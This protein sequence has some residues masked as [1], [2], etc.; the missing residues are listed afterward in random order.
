L[1]KE[2]KKEVGK[3]VEFVE[4]RHKAMQLSRDFNI[5]EKGRNINKENHYHLLRMLNIEKRAPTIHTS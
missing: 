4:R 5:K 3:R 1:V 2:L